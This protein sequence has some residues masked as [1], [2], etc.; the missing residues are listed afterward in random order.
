MFFQK[1]HL[2]SPVIIC[3]LTHIHSLW[4]IVW[5][6]YREHHNQLLAWDASHMSKNIFWSCLNM[7]PILKA[8]IKG[9]YWIK[10][11]WDP[12]CE[13]VR[14]RVYGEICLRFCLMNHSCAQACRVGV[15][16]HSSRLR[17]SSQRLLELLSAVA[18]HLPLSLLQWR[19]CRCVSSTLSF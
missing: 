12:L 13:R 5:S 7:H 2:L 6:A 17:K 16:D 3:Q 10:G 18:N 11:G 4:D 14:M 15:S 19:H 9:P 8:S 1:P